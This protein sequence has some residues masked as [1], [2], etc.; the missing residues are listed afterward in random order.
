MVDEDRWA[1]DRIRRLLGE[2]RLGRK[3]KVLTVLLAW[4]P[5]LRARGALEE[6][7]GCPCVAARR[8]RRSREPASFSWAG[9]GPEST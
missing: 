4:V 6:G 8:R 9:L 5:I 3:G 1:E 7:S 2:R